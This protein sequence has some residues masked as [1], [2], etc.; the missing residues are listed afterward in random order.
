MRGRLGARRA[1]DRDS[2]YWFVLAFGFLWLVTRKATS[3]VPSKLQAFVELCV[4]FV[5]DQV[6]SIYH[7]ESKLIA[8]IV[9]HVGDG[10]FH[11][12]LVCD[13]DN[14]EEMARGE[15]FMHRLVERALLPD[16]RYRLRA[17]A[18]GG[19]PAQAAAIYAACRRNLRR[20]SG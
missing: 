6:K 5:N 2:I 15:E 4:V 19:N 8:P 17:L 7:G 11:C 12:S 20:A 13:V 1:G 9:G 14:H 18:A 10:N 3:G 16:D